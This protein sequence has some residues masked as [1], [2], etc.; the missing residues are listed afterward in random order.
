MGKIAG[1]PTLPCLR[2]VMF[3]VVLINV[4]FVFFFYISSLQKREL[5]GATVVARAA[6][7]TNAMMGNGGMPWYRNNTVDK[8][9]IENELDV[10][11]AKR[12]S[13]SE[14]SSSSSGVR[15]S[16]QDPVFTARKLH[17]EYN[18][19]VKNSSGYNTVSQRKTQKL[20]NSKGSTQ[21]TTTLPSTD[22]VTSQIFEF[23][24]DDYF[25]NYS[26][27]F[28]P[29]PVPVNSYIPQYLLQVREPC[30][31][32]GPYVLVVVPSVHDHAK[33]R[34]FIRNTWGRPA[35][36]GHKT[37]PGEPLKKSVKLVFFL[38]V[39]DDWNRS[40]AAAAAEAVE[41][42]SRLY[43]D[44]VVADL[45]DS[46][47]NLSVKMGAVLHWTATH[48]PDAGHLLKV[49]EDTVVNLP[50]LV[51]LL[52]ALPRGGIQPAAFVLGHRHYYD[53]PTVV[54]SGRWAVG[55]DAY[56]LHHFPRYLYGHCYV[57]SGEAVA[58]FLHAYRHTPLIPVEDAYLTGVLA[59]S[60]GVHRLHS[61]RFVPLLPRQ[62]LYNRCDVL[63]GKHISQTGVK[64]MV[65]M[66][67]VWELFRSGA[68]FRH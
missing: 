5:F 16:E 53:K 31:P 9:S 68:C 62:D 50:A 3:L 19:T 44:I 15:Y 41:T 54:R 46:Y 20:E 18:K 48:C 25:Q 51:T 52:E 67:T 12:V 17:Q 60:V 37:W 39:R 47:R 24:D 14:N 65:V 45:V 58:D 55:R 38:G 22:G 49:D 43:G 36:Y 66:E 57:I 61:D 6:P 32:D 34:E 40:T 13:P 35:A 21:G 4:F 59:R 27:V 42:E 23:H 30:P 29:R 8:P 11:P 1:L 64:P 2:Y 26:S 28:S 63:E 33:E 7:K 10:V 56:P